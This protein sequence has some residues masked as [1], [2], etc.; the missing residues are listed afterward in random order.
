MLLNFPGQQNAVNVVVYPS[1]VGSPD[2]TKE[3]VPP[4]PHKT[5]LASPCFPPYHLPSSRIPIYPP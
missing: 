4:V 3:N 2:D 1:Q 5:F